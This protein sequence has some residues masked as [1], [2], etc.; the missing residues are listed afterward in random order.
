MHAHDDI[1][2]FLL[3]LD[4]EQWL[5]TCYSRPTAWP[6]TLLESPPT[7]QGQGKQTDSSSPGE[8][9]QLQDSSHGSSTLNVQLALNCLT[10]GIVLNVGVHSMCS[11]ERVSSSCAA[12]LDSLLKPVT[13]LQ[14]FSES[15]LY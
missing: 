15:P 9:P 13:L 11:L 10:G 3:E 8:F 7:T 4:T 6:E 5:G 12:I 14:N 2:L 1:L